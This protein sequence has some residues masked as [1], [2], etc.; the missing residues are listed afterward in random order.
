[1]WTAFIPTSHLYWTPLTLT[2]H[3]NRVKPRLHGTGH[4]RLYHGH[5]NQEHSPTEDPT[6]SGCQSWPTPAP[7]QV[8]HQGPSSAEVSSSHG[9][10]QCNG[11]HCFLRGEKWSRCILVATHLFHLGPHHCLFQ[12]F[13]QLTIFSSFSGPELPE[14]FWG[15]KWHFLGKSGATCELLWCV[16]HQNL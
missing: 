11:D 9:G 16:S 5:A 4:H 13:S 10:T 15:P 2:T 12:F 8:V 14:P 6:V 3:T 7:R 1:M